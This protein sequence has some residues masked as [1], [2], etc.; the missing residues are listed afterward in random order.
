MMQALYKLATKDNHDYLTEG[1]YYFF[2]TCAD[3]EIQGN[4]AD[5]WILDFAKLKGAKNEDETEKQENRQETSE[6]V[7]SAPKRGRP[8]AQ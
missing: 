8:K 3:N 5:G 6:K 2:K 1:V 7:L 4:V